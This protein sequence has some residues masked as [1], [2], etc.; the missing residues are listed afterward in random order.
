MCDARKDLEQRWLDLTRRALPG[1]AAARRWPVTADHCFQR[2]LLD[3][4][5]GGC[6]YDHVH[7]RPAYAHA[8][9]PLLAHAVALAEAC[10]DG[11]ADLAELNRRSLAWRGKG[12]QR[13]CRLRR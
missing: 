2:I 11:S 8:P 12:G 9:F 5:C 7:G 4:S 1:V 10:L 6:W 13:P 3:N